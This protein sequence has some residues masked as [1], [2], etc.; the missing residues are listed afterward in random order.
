MKANNILSIL[1]ISAVLG[2]TLGAA[3]AKTTKNPPKV[4][5]SKTQLAFAKADADADGS[6]SVFEFAK[7][8]GPGTPMVEVRSRF[9]AIDVSGAFEEVIDPATGLPAVDPVTGLPVVGAAIPDGWVTLAEWEAYLALEDK[10]KST[11]SRFEL[12]DF[13]GD[14]QL[15]PIEF[16]YL[17]SPRV[18]WR[19]TIRL[20]DKLDTIIDDDMLSP[21]ECTK[22]RPG[23]I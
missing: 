2:L 3:T 5:G 10:P 18:P 12:A 13:D 7:T 21:E 1:S 11:L 8:Q 14:G 9:L 19:N 15:T 22:T 16:G 23:T 4:K 20:F 6:L 17:V